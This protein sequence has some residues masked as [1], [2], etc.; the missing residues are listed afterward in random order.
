MK[1]EH[2]VK[3]VLRYAINNS[4]IRFDYR[5][6]KYWVNPAQDDAK[7]WYKFIGFIPDG[8]VLDIGCGD[9]PFPSATFLVDKKVIKT[10]KPFCLADIEAL[11]FADKEFDFVFCSHVL[12]H[13]LNPL[14]ACRELM[15]VGKRG[16]IETPRI[17]IDA[18]FAWDDSNHN[19]LV[20]N[21]GNTLFFFPLTDSLREGINSTAWRDVL[22]SFWR[23]PLAE[24]FYKNPEVFN[25]MFNWEGKFNAFVF[26]KD[27][28]CLS[29]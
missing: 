21:S 7:L 22:S 8:K 3:R 6:N 12:E 18:L 4:P 15:R 16:Y 1:T 23:H 26:Y 11:P 29:N 24:A 17:S 19:W 5:I 28:R 14:K 2:I 9:R 27:G 13:T 20:H 10:T 25:V